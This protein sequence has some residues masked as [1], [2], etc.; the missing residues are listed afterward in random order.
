MEL[1]IHSEEGV[2]VWGNGRGSWQ[3]KGSSNPIS[4]MSP[5]FRARALHLG[6]EGKH[7]TPSVHA[8][9]SCKVCEHSMF[10]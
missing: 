5:I 2:A 6:A 3:S 10:P 1:S 4:P 9:T 8:P 7:Q